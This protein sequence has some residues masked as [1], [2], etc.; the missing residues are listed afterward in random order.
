MFAEG[1]TGGGIRL[2][3][4]RLGNRSGTASSEMVKEE[5]AVF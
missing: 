5:T 1:L 4:Y 3:H 2:R